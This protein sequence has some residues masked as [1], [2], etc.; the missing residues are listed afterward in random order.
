MDPR[1]E[2]LAANLPHLSPALLAEMTSA[3]QWATFPEGTQI[4]RAGQYIKVIPLVTEGLIRVFTRH[5]DKELL[6]Y[7]IQPFESCIMSFAASLHN[8]PGHV[9]AET[10]EETT[11]LL[12]P[13]DPVIRW[14]RQFPDVNLLFFQYYNQRYSD[15]LS[16][17]HH[18]LYNKL[19]VRLAAY[20]GEKVRLTGRNPIR[21]SHRQIAAELGT[22]R[23]VVSRVMKKLE[24]DGQVRQQGNTIEWLGSD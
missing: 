16:T 6:L 3:G 4:L 22:A 1:T 13:V 8:E 14:T 7:Y 11:A 2:A 15:L 12:L 20:L 23:E 24:S 19:D 17:I 18:L 9:F 10:E 5:E 21:L